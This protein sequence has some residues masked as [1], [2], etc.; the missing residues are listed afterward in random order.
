MR[1][2]AQRDAAK[3][4]RDSA[5][6]ARDALRNKGNRFSMDGGGRY[7]T[8]I[9]QLNLSSDEQLELAKQED[10]VEKQHERYKEADGALDD[11][12]Q[13]SR[14]YRKDVQA[15]LDKHTNNQTLT[16]REK[17]LKAAWEDS[18]PLPVDVQKFFDLF[19]HD[20]IAHFNYDSSRL[21]NWRTIYFGDTKYSPS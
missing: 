2:Q 16:L 19:A 6:R 21:S 15:I 8:P 12:N 14:K 11:L 18:S 17:T 13:E 5:R 9:S 1:L 7:A 20:S 10:A 4:A 3:S